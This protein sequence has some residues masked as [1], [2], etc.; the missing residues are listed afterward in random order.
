MVG[1]VPSMV[2]GWYLAWWGWYLAT[3][4]ELDQ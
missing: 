2:W 4:P 1:V 3:D